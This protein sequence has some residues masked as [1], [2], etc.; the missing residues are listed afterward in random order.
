MN[1]KVDQSH[2]AGAA[3]DVVKYVLAAALVAAGIFAFYWFQWPGPIRGLIAVLGVIAGLA[4][5]S[6]TAKGRDAREFISESMFEL[7]K[8]VWPTRQE[9]MRVTVV[10]LIVVV[11]VS[12]ILALFDFTIS[13]LFKWLLSN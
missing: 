11:V 9:S 3:A 12:L 7:R 5:A 2:Q 1:S 6:F 10:V 4:V 13:A 8:V